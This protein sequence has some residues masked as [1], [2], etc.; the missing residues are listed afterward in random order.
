M[1][2]CVQIL[3]VHLTMKTFY[4]SPKTFQ[5]KEIFIDMF[6]KMTNKSTLEDYQNNWKVCLQTLLN[7]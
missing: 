3:I 2:T 6:L 5:L 7:Y 1:C 4:N